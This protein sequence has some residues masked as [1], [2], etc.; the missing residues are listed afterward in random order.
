MIAYV[1]SHAIAL[2]AARTRERGLDELGPGYKAG[3]LKLKG[4]SLGGGDGGSSGKRF[5][6]SGGKSFG[7]RGG[8][9]GGRG[10]NRGVNTGATRAALHKTKGLGG[11]RPVGMG[12]KKGKP[13]RLPF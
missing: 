13:M 2:N 3:V 12:K 8:R 5:G 10:G 7:G 6:D 9:G 4:S 1:V 11:M